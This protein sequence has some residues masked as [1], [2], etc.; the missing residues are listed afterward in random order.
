MHDARGAYVCAHAALRRGDPAGALAELEHVNRLSW[1]P[2][3]ELL[4]ARAL[5][6]LGREDEARAAITRPRGV[7]DHAAVAFGV[8]RAES[9]RLDEEV[10]RFIR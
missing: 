2:D 9:D 5:L 7:S 3:G 6:A 10:E 8:T 4:R 1:R